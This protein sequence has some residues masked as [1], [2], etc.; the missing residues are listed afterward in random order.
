[1]E[2]AWEIWRLLEWT[3]W[4][5]PP[6]VLLEQPAELMKDVAQ[7]HWYSRVVKESMV[8]PVGAVS[9]PVTDRGPH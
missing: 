4:R 5:W 7:L 9:A 8:G 1:M 6:S 2:Q 3:D